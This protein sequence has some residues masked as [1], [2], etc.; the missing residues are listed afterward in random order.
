MSAS[1]TVQCLQ[2]VHDW[3]QDQS[4]TLWIAIGLLAEQGADRSLID[5][6]R[7]QFVKHTVFATHLKAAIRELNGE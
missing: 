7:E 4:D 1:H 6:T 5:D 2:Q 3:H